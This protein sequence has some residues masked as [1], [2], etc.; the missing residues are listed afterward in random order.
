LPFF[1]TSGKSTNAKQKGNEGMHQRDARD[2][3]TTQRKEYVPCCSH[4]VYASG[5]HKCGVAVYW[6][7]NDEKANEVEETIAK[8]IPQQ[9][10]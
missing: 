1:L 7:V 9:N 2:E 8:A 10:L 4:R 3:R 5:F 6:I